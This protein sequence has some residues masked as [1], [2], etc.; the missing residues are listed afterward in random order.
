[1]VEG[2]LDLAEGVV[3]PGPVQRLVEGAAGPAVTVLAGEGAAELENQRADLLGDPLHL[4]DLAVVLQVDQRPD[5]ETPHRAVAVVAGGGVV[6]A[7][8]FPEARDERGE[9]GRIDGGV[10][11]EGDRLLL[12]LEPEEEPEARLA[13]LPDRLLLGRVERPVRRVADP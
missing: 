11:D 1:R 4:P 2:P 8:D 5:V 10:L 7:E 13:E 9:P 3:E 12:A 6:A